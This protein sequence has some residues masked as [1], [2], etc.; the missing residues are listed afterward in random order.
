M[1]TPVPAKIDTVVDLTVEVRSADG[2]STE[3]YQTNEECIRKTLR[4]LTTPRVFT[5]PQL[6]LASEHS[7]NTI[8]CRSIDMILA[9]TLARTP[10][11]FPLIF[12]AGLL[13]AVEAKSDWP[14][15][16][17]TDEEQAGAGIAGLS[18]RVSHLEIHTPGGWVVVLR[19]LATARDTYDQR[20]ASAQLCELPVIPF[21]L[22]E[23]GIGLINPNN[24]TRVSTRPSPAALPETALPI[25]L[26][27][28]NPSRF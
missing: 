15:E 9:R 11:I 18:P 25:D 7:I 17:S 19:L 1:N 21:R 2:T 23:G 27:R 4:S 26:L 13:D 3:F 10:L 12:P 8:P 24:I 28:W 20:P 14:G 16:P 5:Q 6:V 22:L